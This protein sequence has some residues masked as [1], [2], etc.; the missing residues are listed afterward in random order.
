MY[1]YASLQNT[2]ISRVYNLWREYLIQVRKEN[3][4]TQYGEPGGSWNYRHTFN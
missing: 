1:V 3:V 2:S 4:R